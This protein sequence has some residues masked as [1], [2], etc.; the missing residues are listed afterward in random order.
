[1]RDQWLTWEARSRKEAAAAGATIIDSI[2]RRPFE[3]ATE[4][5]RKKLRADPHLG[6]LIARI[7]AER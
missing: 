6:A 1:M 3:A 5:L 2:D 7:E 4:A